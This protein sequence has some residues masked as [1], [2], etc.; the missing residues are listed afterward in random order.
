M[1]TPLPEYSCRV[2]NLSHGR[3]I[4]LCQAAISLID[5][6]PRSLLTFAADEFV[7]SVTKDGS[8]GHAGRHT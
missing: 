8:A 5:S 1:I 2:S 3:L 6:R 4:F 7:R